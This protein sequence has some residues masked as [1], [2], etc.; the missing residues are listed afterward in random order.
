MSSEQQPGVIVVDRGHPATRDG[1][2]LAR[3]IGVVLRHLRDAFGQRLE[4]PEQTSGVFTVQYPEERTPLPEA[5][6]NLPILLFD[7]ESGHELCTSCYQCE[8]ICPPQVIHITQARD[9]A[10][11]K[12][13]PAIDEFILE[14][15]ACMSCGLCAEVCPFDAI[16][17]DHAF[18][19]ATATRDPLTVDRAGL[20]RPVSY[21]AQL[22][23]QAWAEAHDGAMKKLQ[24]SRKRRT[25]TVGITPARAAAMTPASEPVSA[26]PAPASD[27]KAARLAAIRARNAAASGATPAPTDGAAP[28]PTSSGQAPASDDKAAR[29]AAIR[30]RNA[31]RQREGGDS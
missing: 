26:A 18:E 21:Y 8:R 9:P 28:A 29:L 15:D 23:P 27:D 5:S 3:G 25:G 17:M 1:R 13:V 20:A 12:A 4:R 31:A 19:L 24:G 22:A 30:E 16:K 7:D 11:G 6:R 2:G 10:S 14:Y